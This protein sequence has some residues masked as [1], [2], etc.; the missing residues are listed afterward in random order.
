M[1]K[2]AYDDEVYAA[3]R[4][5]TEELMAAVSLVERGEPVNPMNISQAVDQLNEAWDALTDC[6]VRQREE[7]NVLI[8]EL[9]DEVAELKGRLKR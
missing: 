5:V 1:T 9:V 4:R 3:K 6:L 2:R 7:R 8:L